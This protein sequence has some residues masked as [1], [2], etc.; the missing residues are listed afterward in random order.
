MVGEY[1][2]SGNTVLEVLQSF[3]GA[4]QSGFRDRKEG[5]DKVKPGRMVFD[6]CEI[7]R[8]TMFSLD[9]NV[10]IDVE[11]SVGECCRD[12][13]VRLWDDDDELPGLTELNVASID[14]D[15]PAGLDYGESALDLG[16]D[17]WR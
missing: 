8:G 4:W 1:G 15:S 2:G 9:L 13:G 5:I 7:R 16:I 10:S 11:R 12:V 17:A 3:D 14:L 6:R